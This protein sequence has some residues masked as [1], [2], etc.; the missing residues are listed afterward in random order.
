[1]KKPKID[2]LKFAAKEADNYNTLFFNGFTRTSIPTLVLRRA[3]T[4][5][6]LLTQHIT[7]EL[8]NE[9]RGEFLFL[10]ESVKALCRRQDSRRG[11]LEERFLRR[12]ASIRDGRNVRLNSEWFTYPDAEFEMES[13]FLYSVL[14]FIRNCEFE[15]DEETP[16]DLNEF[17]RITDKI[18]EFAK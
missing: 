4:R 17:A 3:Q 8:M 6:F 5:L 7:E 15:S 13:M 12:L 16:F 2:T 9:M 11:L 10:C 18:R 14:D 1:M